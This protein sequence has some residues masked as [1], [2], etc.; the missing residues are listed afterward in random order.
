MSEAESAHGK[1]SSVDRQWNQNRLLVLFTGTVLA[2]L[3]IIY[4]I[5]SLKL[6]DFTWN[7]LAHDPF[8]HTWPASNFL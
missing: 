5:A 1:L 3:V 7:P 6:G 8:V 4:V 2:A